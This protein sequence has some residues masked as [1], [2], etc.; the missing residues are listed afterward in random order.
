VSV[1]GHLYALQITSGKLLWQQ[2]VVATPNF[3]AAMGSLRIMAGDTA[4][5]VGYDMRGPRRAAVYVFKAQN[6]APLWHDQAQAFNQGVSL[7]GVDDTA[8]YI[9][10]TSPQGGSFVTRARLAM[11]GTLLWTSP[12]FIAPAA[13]AGTPSLVIVNGVLYG[14]GNDLQAVQAQ[15]GKLLWEQKVSQDGMPAQITTGNHEVYLVTQH[16]FCAY[17]MHDGA[18]LW[19]T[20]ARQGNNFEAFEQTVFMNGMAYVGR[21]LYNNPDGLR[22]EAWDANKGTLHWAW[23]ADVSLLSHDFSWLF[24]GSNGMLYVPVMQGIYAIRGSDG[25]QLWFATMNMGFGPIVPAP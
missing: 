6:G 14:Y 10:D 20:H 15:N 23:P 9:T 24:A 21:G 12:H 7:V 16:R 17:R 19:C 1:D 5:A 18:Q 2:L 11:K 4:V 25:H 3:S 22:I 8:V 13:W